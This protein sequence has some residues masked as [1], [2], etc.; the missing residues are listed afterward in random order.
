M[1]IVKI[2]RRFDKKTPF[3]QERVLKHFISR[4]FLVGPYRT[5]LR[6]FLW[7]YR[8]YLW[9]TR[10]RLIH[11]VR[12]NHRSGRRFRCF[13]RNRS[14][15]FSE[16]NDVA[17]GR[18]NGCCCNLPRF[19]NVFLL[20]PVA[21]EFVRHG[22]AERIQ[23]RCEPRALRRSFEDLPERCDVDIRAG[24][25]LEKPQA[26]W[27]RVAVL[28]LP[29]SQTNVSRLHDIPPHPASWRVCKMRPGCEVLEVKGTLVTFHR[30]GVLTICQEKRNVC[31][32]EKL[33]YRTSQS[34]KCGCTKTR[35]FRFLCPSLCRQAGHQDDP[36]SP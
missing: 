11:A 35:T 25:S 26:E 10:N 28:L 13:G 1:T 30:R 33:G 6:G 8:L 17:E 21:L 32:R 19:L 34:G 4:H 9:C 2:S 15:P 18:I 12:G 29:G 22:K 31:K 16:S 36:S 14:M 3:S 23:E 20:I 7:F 27:T 5:W 24:E